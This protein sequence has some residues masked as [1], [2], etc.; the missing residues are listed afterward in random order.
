MTPPHACGAKPIPSGRRAARPI[1]DKLGGFLAGSMRTRRSILHLLVLLLVGLASTAEAQGY[2]R[3]AERV[4]SRAFTATGGSGWYLLRG[5]RETGRR[6]DLAYESW[7]DPLRYGLRTETREA[8]GLAVHGFNGLADWRVGSNGAMTAVNDHPT[9]AKARTEA[10]FAVN[11][12]FFRGRFD[13][14]GDYVGVRRLGRRAYEVVR[15]QPWGGEPRELWFDQRSRLLA[16][17]VNRTGRRAAALQVTDYRKVGPVL[18]PFRFAPEP[19]GPADPLARQRESLVFTPV[20]RDGFSLNRPDELA[21]VQAAK[22][23]H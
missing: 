11:G 12:Y 14:R 9:V 13:A 22:L 17:I 2:S 19:G 3:A 1:L 20:T 10:F 5:W 7:I 6:G 15:I 21:K 4:L 16:R 18:I 8:E 23:S